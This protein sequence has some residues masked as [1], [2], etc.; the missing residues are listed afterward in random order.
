M[1]QYLLGIDIGTSACKTAVFD[2][3][4]HVLASGS[5]D[6]PV[7]YPRQGWAEQNPE[8]W[9]AAVCRA[10]KEMLE[11]SLPIPRSGWIPARRISARK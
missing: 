6:Y 1:K 11:M 3:N 4:G 9:W 2:E 7:Y 10:I 8:E 5:G